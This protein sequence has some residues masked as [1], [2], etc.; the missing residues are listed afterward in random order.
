MELYTTNGV[1]FFRE[2]V[3][4]ERSDG[5]RVPLR[6]MSVQHLRNALG[7]PIIQRRQSYVPF[8]ELELNR[9]NTS[10]RHRSRLE[11]F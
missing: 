9:A 4:W 8:I 1:E 7:H 3:M 6:T 5:T 10:A 2:M 11:P